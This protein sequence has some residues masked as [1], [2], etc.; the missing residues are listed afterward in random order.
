MK[1]VML[2]MIAAGWLLAGCS[3]GSETKDTAADWPELES[4]HELMAEA[5]HPVADSGNFEP[6]RKG[7]ATL[8]Q[9]ARKWSDAPVPGKLDK[10]EVSARI[11]VLLDSCTSFRKAVEAGRPDSLL[12]PSLAEM[13]HLFHKLQE[14][15]HHAGQ[16]EGDHH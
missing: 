1:N 6:A 11:R 14:S 8:E 13:H 9:E 10:Q 7:A 4:F 5:W 16:E 15:W 3:G 2:T 12:R